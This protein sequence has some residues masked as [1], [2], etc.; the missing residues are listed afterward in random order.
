VSRI[1]VA[2]IE[3]AR[4]YFTGTMTTV[5][6][7][8]NAMRNARRRNPVLDI[9]WHHEGW[10]RESPMATIYGTPRVVLPIRGAG[11][12]RPSRKAL[13]ASRARSTPAPTA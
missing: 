6:T 4:V 8:A 5:H 1:E 9:G 7:F 2:S 11:C 12:S 3:L 13:R 10:T